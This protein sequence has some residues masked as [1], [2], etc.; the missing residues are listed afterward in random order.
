MKKTILII[1]ALFTFAATVNARPVNVEYARK[2]A[3]F[4]WNS[5]RPTD[6]KPAATVSA[7][8]F[9]GLEHLHVF[10][11]NGEGFVIVAG[12]DRVQP[13]LAYSFANTFP[14]EL[15]PEVG[16]WL[17]GY[18][19]QITEVAQSDVPQRES[20]LQ[21]WTKPLLS[22]APVEPVGSL[23]DIPALMHTHWN[24]SAPYNNLCPYDSSRHGR[25]VVGCVA[26]A[27]AQIMRYWSYPAYGQGEYSYTYDNLG[28]IYADFENTSYLW[29]IMPAICN[30]FTPAPSTRAVATISYH[31]GVAVE[32][33]YGVS[34]IGGSGAYSDCGWWTSHC[35][36]SAFTNYFK[37]DTTVYHADRISY[38]EPAWT[39]IIDNELELHHPIYYS[40][41][42]STGGH[43]FVLDGSD[44]DGRYHFNWGWGG[45]GDGFYTINNLAPSRTHGA[46]GGNATYTFNQGQGA[47]FGIQPG[48]T[49]VFDTVEVFDSVC[50]NTQYAYFRNYQLL[51]A[52]VA[53]RDTILHNFDTV[54]LYHLSVIPK[55]RLYLD[56]N[57]GEVAEIKNYCPATGYTF[58]QCTFH[59]T[60]CIFTGWCRNK[61][62]NGII[63][64]PGE[65]GY[66]NN[67]PTFYA[68][69]VDTSATV[70]I[71]PLEEEH[72]AVWPTMTE[73]LVNI[74]FDD[75]DA[76]TINIID[77]WGRVVIQKESVGRKAKISLDRLPAG[78]YTVQIITKGT[79][80]K[81]R[82]IKL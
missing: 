20:I 44:L 78:T 9:S 12:D 53:G 37:Y 8:T 6:V 38:S 74:S 41:H 3:T 2:V 70:G 13:V 79:I 54:F 5:Y 7:M 80:Y 45:F 46:P 42:D 4:F 43:A 31:C 68:L 56:P 34:A 26:T 55:E 71:E 82:I 50:E 28:E 24:Q 39:E 18:E 47:I 1:A 57:N 73:D 35:A 29:H 25:T 10:D 21:L 77:N 40:G 32:M 15:N 49:E 76:F 36:T 33:M 30:E 59:K 14:E 23:Q 17:R 65:I 67:T 81:S 52:N 19:A 60:N 58:P 75:A 69:W 48:T 51:V 62:G 16:Y 61:Y 72:I 66:F 63:Y 27:M 64:Q 22:P 11:I